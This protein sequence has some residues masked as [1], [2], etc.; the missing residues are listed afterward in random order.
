[1]SNADK[2]VNTAGAQIDLT[3]GFMQTPRLRVEFRDRFDPAG[4]QSHVHRTETDG[5]KRFAIRRLLKRAGG[6]ATPRETDELQSPVK[7]GKSQASVVSGVVSGRVR[8]RRDFARDSLLK[9][10]V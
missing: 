9:S 3:N 4:N 7:A 1:M 6:Q 2:T 8:E 5:R 10:T